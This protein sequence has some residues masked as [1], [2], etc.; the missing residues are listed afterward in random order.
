MFLHYLVHIKIPELSPCNFAN[1][2]N[3]LAFLY[4][5]APIFVS[6]VRRWCSTNCNV[7]LLYCCLNLVFIA[8]Y[9]MKTRCQNLEFPEL[10]VKIAFCFFL[11]LMVTVSEGAQM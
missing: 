4:S 9:T 3:V 11:K 2:L 5:I 7:F 1:A 6:L 10:I 8:Q